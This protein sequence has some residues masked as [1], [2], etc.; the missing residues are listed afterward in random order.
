MMI[1][2]FGGMML[3]IGFLLGSIGLKAATSSQAKQCYAK[4]IAKGLQ[5]KSAYQGI[6]EQA[7]AEVDDIVAEAN[8]LNVQAA[9]KEAEESETEAQE[10]ADK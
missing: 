7:K 4:G 10:K 3:G 8:Y 6:V 2:K 9:E 1:G 5:V